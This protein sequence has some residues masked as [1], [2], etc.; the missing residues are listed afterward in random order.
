MSN[1]IDLS[2]KRFGKLVVIKREENASNG[3]ARWLCKCDCGK[4]KIIRGTA[5][6]HGLT[7][8]C[9]CYHKQIVSNKNN[10]NY[11]HGK[12]NTRLYNIYNNM[13]ARCYNK[14]H[15]SYKIYGGRGIKICKEWLN[16]KKR[17][18]KLL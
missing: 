17:I 12:C 10:I 14:N 1:F 4:H 3:D 13:K 6:N 5:L 9:G 8:S 16:K 2:G 15:K 18:Y 7:V 11:K